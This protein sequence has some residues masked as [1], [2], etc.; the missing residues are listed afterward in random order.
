MWQAGHHG[1]RQATL[2]RHVAAPQGEVWRWILDRGEYNRVDAPSSVV[3]VARYMK[4]L[5]TEKT[6]R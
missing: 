6:T 3:P 5:A 4:S 2:S 1:R